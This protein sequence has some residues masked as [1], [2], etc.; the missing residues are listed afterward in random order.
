M[1]AADAACVRDGS[2]YVVNY[3]TNGS[4]KV[5]SVSLDGLKVN[6]VDLPNTPV[7]VAP[8]VPAA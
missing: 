5:T 7:A 8:V 1:D 2:G 4:P 6:G 3:F